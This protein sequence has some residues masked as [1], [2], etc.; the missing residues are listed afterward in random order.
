MPRSALALF[1]LLLSVVGTGCLPVGYGGSLS[2][3][4][5]VF[6]GKE[7]S[8]EAGTEASFHFYPEGSRGLAMTADIGVTSASP[9]TAG[10]AGLG[11]GYA[12][13]PRPFEARVGYELLARGGLGNMPGDC[14]LALHA[15]A[16][17][18]LLY[19]LGHDDTV[20]HQDQSLS[21][22][23]WFVGPFVSIEPATQ[24]NWT[25]PWLDNVAGIAVYAL[26][27]NTG[28]P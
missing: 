7:T 12:Y 9:G 8:G 23:L 19:R 11:A 13:I 26:D 4:G 6:H 25:N 5:G 20:W 21:H 16:R 10:R 22:L 14:H 17:L 18:A 24:S 2:G 28:A 3:Y 27:Y 1:A 15:G